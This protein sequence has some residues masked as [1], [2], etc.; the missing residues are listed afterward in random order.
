MAR[1]KDLQ[2]S[3]LMWVSATAG[4]RKPGAQRRVSWVNTSPAHCH[5]LMDP[6]YL[7]GRALPT[8]L[9]SYML[10]EK[11]GKPGWT[12]G[13]GFHALPLCIV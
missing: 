12:E 13:Q 10:G 8:P 11:T 9:R 5:L 2:P 6:E 3:E 7:G 1:K 4:K